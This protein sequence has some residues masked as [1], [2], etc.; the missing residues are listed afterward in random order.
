[1]PMFISPKNAGVVSGFEPVELPLVEHEE[2]AL[3]L[4]VE[5]L[6]RQQAQKD[7]P[8]TAALEPDANEL[9][10]ANHIKVKSTQAKNRVSESEANIQAELQGISIAREVS[11]IRGI[12]EGFERKCFAYFMPALDNLEELKKGLE[13]AVEEVGDFKRKHNLRRE[14]NYPQSN[15]L[16][17]AVLLSA[18]VVETFL[19]GTFFVT[20]S[21]TRLVGGVTVA[22]LVAA[23][24]IGLGFL[25]GWWLLPYKNHAV[26]WQSLSAL[27]CTAVL[28][29][30][31]FL[32]NLLVGHYRQA[33]VADPDSAAR[34]AVHAFRGGVLR[35]DDVSSWLLFGVGMMFCLLAVYK[36]Y[37][38]N[39]PYPGYGRLAKRRD[40]LQADITEERNEAL[41]ELDELHDQFLETMGKHYASIEHKFSS[42]FRLSSAFDLQ[43]RILWTYVDH[44]QDGFKYVVTLYR[45]TNIAER[46]DGA[47]EYFKKR[48][49][50]GLVLD[51]DFTETEELFGARS[52]L[53]GLERDELAVLQP[54]LRN[55]LLAIKECF[56]TKLGGVGD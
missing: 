18:L 45:D 46:Q 41:K 33:L 31:P 55:N 2:L 48:V 51:F 13:L 7:M 43:L 40:K 17:F 47:P 22:L 28:A 37:H 24:N 38:F 16:S 26:Q 3:E 29:W 27:L 49:D 44:L 21:D 42:L 54:E 11:V 36:G 34:L 20:G 56:H 39:D 5:E 15:W 52:R 1:M 19:N 8:A 53:I 14:A 10:F 6:A 12:R 9:N 30:L 50:S 4:N 32:F 23:F 35:I 25:L